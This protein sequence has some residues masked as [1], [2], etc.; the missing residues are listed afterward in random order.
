[1]KMSARNMLNGKVEGVKVGQVMASVKI[2]IESPDVITAI[3]T[4]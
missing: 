1:M 2:K 4:K 3:I